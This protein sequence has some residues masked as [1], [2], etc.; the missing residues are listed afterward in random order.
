M[1]VMNWCFIHVGILADPTHNVLSSSEGSK[2]FIKKQLLGQPSHLLLKK[3][4]K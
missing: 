1:T 4:K 2:V 3:T